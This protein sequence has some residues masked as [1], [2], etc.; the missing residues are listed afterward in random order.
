M[1]SA[2]R[3]SELRLEVFSAAEFLVSWR[4][5]QRF[6]GELLCALC[7]LV[8]LARNPSAKARS[9]ALAAVGNELLLKTRGKPAV[10]STGVEME[11]RGALAGLAPLLKTLPEQCY[12]GQTP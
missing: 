12:A 9:A 10:N 3:R 11:V 6:G 2:R 5:S 1:P 7:T 8:Q 4:A